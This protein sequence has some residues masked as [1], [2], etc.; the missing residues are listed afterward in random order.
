MT[1]EES[2]FAVAVIISRIPTQG[3]FR[4]ARYRLL[5]WIPL[6]DS[7]LHTSKDKDRMYLKISPIYDCRVACTCVFKNSKLTT[8]K[9]LPLTGLALKFLSCFFYNWNMYTDKSSCFLTILKIWKTFLR[10]KKHLALWFTQN[11]V[12]EKNQPP[13]YQPCILL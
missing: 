10:K 7:I 11:I 4:E 1:K 2:H 12:S 5:T 3:C 8:H 6:N 9:T 13:I